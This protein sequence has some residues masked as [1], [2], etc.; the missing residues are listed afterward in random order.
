MSPRKAATATAEPKRDAQGYDKDGW[1]VV[2][3]SA[4][5]VVTDAEWKA[6]CAAGCPRPEVEKIDRGTRPVAVLDANGR[7][8]KPPY[9]K[10]VNDGTDHCTA[11]GDPIVAVEHTRSGWK[12]A[13]RWAER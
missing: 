4:G 6:W 13:K 5:R 7:K 3:S 11:C 9:H 12:H 8:V 1:R 10:I 2:F